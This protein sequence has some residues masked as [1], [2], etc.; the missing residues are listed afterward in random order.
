MT[1]CN[2]TVINAL[3]GRLALLRTLHGSANA[4]T[5]A[6]QLAR[7]DVGFFIRAFAF[8]FDP[9]QTPADQP[10]V[11]YAFQSNLI[12]TLSRSMQHGEDVLIE[13]SRDMGVTWTIVLMFLHAWLFKPG[14]HALLGSRKEDLVD[15]RGDISTLFGKLRFALNWLPTFLLPEGFTPRLHDSHMRLIN[16]ANGNTLTG[17][18]SNDQFGRGGR[19]SAVLMDEF[20]FWPMDEAAWSAVGQSTPCRI[21]VGTPY[22]KNNTF[23]RLRFDSPIQVVRLHWELHPGKNSALNPGWI[24][25]Q[26]TRMSA[27]E[28]ARE[29]EIQYTL[30]L[31]NRVF[32]GFNESHRA[33]ALSPV[34][35]KRI[36]RAWDFGFHCPACLFIQ[37]KDNQQWLILE[38][39]TGQQ[40]LL[41]AFA[42]QVLSVSAARYSGFDFEDVCDPAGAQRSDKSDTSSIEILN[43][44]GVYPFYQPTRILPTLEL[45]R[46]KLAETL[47]P[48]I[49]PVNDLNAQNAD[50]NHGPVFGPEDTPDPGLPEPGL[51][52]DAE[53][54]PKLIEAFEGG[55]R[56][57]N[58]NQELPMQEHPY[59]D[60]IDCLRY[61]V[62]AKLSP[63][64]LLGRV[65]NRSGRRG[66]RRYSSQNPLTGY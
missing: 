56:Y 57:S 6:R 66:K 28:R 1:N 31:S 35:N 46:M 36:I 64:S 44:L 23:A 13:K 24:A 45:I 8:S 11:P 42:R 41:S 37:I 15:R 53:K 47:P 17:E 5:L 34:P 52:V 32:A 22:G 30:S 27:E 14:F 25:K 21:A 40:T 54:C 4:Q 62:G 29:L 50:A 60:V 58:A 43:A 2:K 9:R 51:K 19:Y 48:E 38:E 65:N 18:S 16:P 26:Q 12:K 63:N 49:L 59:E 7:R 33:R 20:P 55:Y 3:G 61:A 39:L 10:Y